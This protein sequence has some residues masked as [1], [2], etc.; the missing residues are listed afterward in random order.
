MLFSGLSTKFVAATKLDANLEAAWF[1]LKQWSEKN[2]YDLIGVR[3]V[4]DALQFINSVKIIIQ[5]IKTN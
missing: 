2:R 5:W 4:A 3:S 1:N